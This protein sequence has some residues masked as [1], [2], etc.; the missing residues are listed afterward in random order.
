MARRKNRKDAHPVGYVLIADGDTE[1]WYVEL[2]KDYICRKLITS[3]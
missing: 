3:Y 2:V 1:Q